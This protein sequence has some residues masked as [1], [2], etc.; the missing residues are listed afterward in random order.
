M[1]TIE[2]SQV[3][4]AFGATQAV[5]DVSFAVE[6]GEIVGLLGPNGA[7]KTTTIRLILDIFK[8][9]RGTVSILGGSMTEEKK[10]R[11]GY[12]PE[13]RGLYQDMQL[14]QCLVYLG[15]LKGMSK[16]AAQDRVG[17]YLERFD[18]A[19]H[20]RKKSKEL[21][22]GMQQKA[23]IISTVLHG[24]E[25]LILDEPFSGLDPVN[26]QLVK[27][28]LLE[29]RAAGSTIIM[30]T[31][32]MRQVEE[33]CDR[34]L[35]IDR[36][37]NVLY[38]PLDQI[39]RD[40]SGHAVSLQVDGDLPHLAGVE[41][42]GQRNGAQ[43][44]SLSIGTNPQDILQQLVA[45]GITVQQFEIAMPTLDEIFIRVVGPHAD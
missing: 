28:L 22:R 38:G 4:K 18:L 5:A 37:S 33:L 41:S 35:L 9:D 12:M 24:P 10:D 44:L 21:S 1:H 36:G 31:H 40:H 15:R 11:V 26:T 19:Q 43:H 2:V 8:P 14:E 39:R 27:D 3:A 32:M 20:K 13:E 42:T 23:Q 25:L 30:S 6:R 16:T 7:G 34:I 29:L 45:Q 17:A